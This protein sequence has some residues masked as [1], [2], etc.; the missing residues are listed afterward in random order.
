MNF[1]LDIIAA[2]SIGIL[3]SGHC[4][5]MCGPIITVLSI[6]S[7]N[8]KYKIL[9]NVGRILSYIFMVIILN[10]LGYFFL[11][12]SVIYIKIIIKIIGN[13][14]I[15]LIGLYIANILNLIHYLERITLKLWILISSIINKINKEKT[16]NSILLGFIW[17]YIPCGLTYNMAIWTLSFE[18]LIKSVI[19]MF[20]FG[21]GTLPSMLLTSYLTSKGN[22]YN[23]KK[24]IKLIAGLIIIIFGIT[25][26]ITV[27][28]NND[29]H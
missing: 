21:I 4:L 29:C 24:E 25:N 2:L 9:Y 28:V 15:I 20:F 16:I 27:L 23:I 18:S 5:G 14:S 3:S 6:K 10:Y 22:F 12:S 8:Y 19:L 26:I 13:I 11:N 7:K 1:K 17:G